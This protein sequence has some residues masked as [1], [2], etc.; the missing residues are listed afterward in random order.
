[1]IRLFFRIDAMVRLIF[2]AI[3]LAT[4]LPVPADWREVAQGFA[5]AAIFLLFLIYG[6]RL[7]RQEVLGGLGNYRL[8]APLAI[9]VFGVMALAGWGVWHLSEP[10]APA[11]IALG[12]LYLGVL[13]STVQ[14]A[15]I[16]SSL[17]GGNVAS[18][19][20]AAALLNVL[21]VFVSA[22]LFS[23]LAGSA[24]FALHGDTLVKVLTMLLLPFVLGQASQRWTRKWALDNKNA[25]SLLD[26][27]A[28]AFSV[29]VAFSGAVIQGVWSTVDL[30]VWG[31]IA[32]GC[33]AMMVLAHAGSW[34]LGGALGLS[35]PDRISMLF[36]GGQKSVAMGAPL[37][38]ILFTGPMAGVIILPMLFYHMTQMVVA[39]V[40]AGRLNRGVPA[41]A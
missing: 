16:Y 31:I 11:A 36:A 7:S 29:Y 28:I 24:G 5:N 6:I 17:A 30:P 19:I 12:F 39:A 3:L 33:G 13:P 37:A 27:G 9:W 38:S 40:L 22:P 2:G 20:V 41:P 4:L 32:I 25:V 18:S 8:L 21:G 26:R 23:I 34:L 14:A 15:T 1:M 10:F 35:R